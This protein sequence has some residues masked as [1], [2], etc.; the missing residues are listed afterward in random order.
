MIWKLAEEGM[1]VARLN[2]SH[3]DHA[4]HL[5]TIEFVREYNAQFND[6]VIS[7]ML[8]TKVY[9]LLYVLYIILLNVVFWCSFFQEYILDSSDLVLKLGYSKVIC[10]LN[11]S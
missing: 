11:Y 8:D 6:K 10:F 3:G 2:M 5:K 7:I 4:S 9:L 1:N